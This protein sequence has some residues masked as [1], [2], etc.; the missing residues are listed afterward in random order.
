[1]R[2]EAFKRARPQLSLGKL[3]RLILRIH[4]RSGELL[5]GF[6][7]RCGTFVFTLAMQKT[8][9]RCPCDETDFRGT[10]L[11][12]IGLIALNGF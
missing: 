1:M 8:F 10:G 12:A 9:A 3:L 5:P 6:G 2:S 7:A 11:T 4:P